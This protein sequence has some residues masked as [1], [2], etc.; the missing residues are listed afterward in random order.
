MTSLFETSRLRIQPIDLVQ[1][2]DT[3]LII[4]NHFNTMRW[5]PNNKSPWTE[6]DIKQ[7]YQRNQSLY[8]LQL[9]LYKIVLKDQTSP[10][11]IGELGLFPCVDSSTSIEIGYI[12]HENYWKQ[13]LGTALLEGLYTFVQQHCT[14]TVLRAQLFETNL[15]SKKLLERCGHQYEGAEAIPGSHQKLIYS[16]RIIR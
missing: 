6:E 16:K 1:D 3:L 9:G 7:K 5:I 12:L 15:S 11:L 2:L 10:T 8:P 14:Y 13:G 4:H